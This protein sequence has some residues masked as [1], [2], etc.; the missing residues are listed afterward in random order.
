MRAI[1]GTVGNLRFGENSILYESPEHRKERLQKSKKQAAGR[2]RRE[3]AEGGGGQ[4]KW[5]AHY[6]PDATT[7]RIKTSGKGDRQKTGC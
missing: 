5:D 3:G 4:E 7:T 2:K 1:A 6:P